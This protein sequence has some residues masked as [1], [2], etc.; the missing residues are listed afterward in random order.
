[1]KASEGE[2]QNKT[3]TKHSLYPKDRNRRALEAFKERSKVLG[4]GRSKD[5]QH[6]MHSTQCTAHKRCT[7]H[8]PQH[9]KASG[10]FLVTLCPDVGWDSE[11]LPK[12][13]QA[14]LGQP[15][16][17]EPQIQVRGLVRQ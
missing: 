3:K 9:T 6:T 16:S 1:M 12:V 5:A 10:T 14:Q 4:K 11:V 13:S 7:A 2:V 8:N 15:A 17:Q